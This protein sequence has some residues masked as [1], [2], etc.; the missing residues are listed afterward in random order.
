MAGGLLVGLLKVLLKK[1]QGPSPIPLDASLHGVPLDYSLRGRINHCLC[2]NDLRQCLTVVRV[3]LLLIGYGSLISV[4]G[5]PRSCCAKLCSWRSCG[6][7]N[8]SCE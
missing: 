1:Q 4:A 5:W 8:C 2:L 3:E 6:C 7:L